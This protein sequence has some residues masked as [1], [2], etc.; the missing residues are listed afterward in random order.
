MGEDLSPL[1]VDMNMV[2][3]ILNSEKTRLAFS[4]I[5]ITNTGLVTLLEASENISRSTMMMGQT[6]IGGAHFDTPE[7]PAGLIAV[8]KSTKLMYNVP[9]TRDGPTVALHSLLMQGGGSTIMNLVDIPIDEFEGRLVNG[10]PLTGGISASVI[11]RVPTGR[12]L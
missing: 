12:Q 6:F 7:R 8:S 9:W 5:V 1:T 11:G 10:D 3:R 4:Y 2:R